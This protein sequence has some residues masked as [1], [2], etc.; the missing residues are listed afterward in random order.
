MIEAIIQNNAIKANALVNVFF[1]IYYF[2]LSKTSERFEIFVSF[3][4]I[5]FQSTV[6]DLTTSLSTTILIFFQLLSNFKWISLSK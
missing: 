6:K 2:N 3:S 4:K 1:F 5:F